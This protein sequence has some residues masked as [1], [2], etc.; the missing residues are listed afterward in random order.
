MIAHS[1]SIAGFITYTYS[2]AL[3]ALG[4]NLAALQRLVVKEWRLAT[5]GGRAHTSTTFFCHGRQQKDGQAQP[6]WVHDGV[7]SLLRLERKVKLAP[8]L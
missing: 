7:D 1:W 2:L 8:R 4:D 6:L 3:Y 5:H